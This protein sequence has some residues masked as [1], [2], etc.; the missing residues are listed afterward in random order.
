MSH[1][2]IVE[3]HALLILVIIMGPAPGGVGVMVTNLPIDS[4][5]RTTINKVR[6]AKAE[7][8]AAEDVL[9]ARS[10]LIIVLP[11]TIQQI[12]PKLPIEIIASPQEIN[13]WQ[14]LVR[15]TQ[16][17][18]RQRQVL[19]TRRKTWVALSLTVVVIVQ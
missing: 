7:A 16:L 6:E 5:T 17:L 15:D 12:G 8:K 13:S 1:L 2:Q 19:K 9:Q 10:I 18:H 11:S 3:C 4:P 14:H